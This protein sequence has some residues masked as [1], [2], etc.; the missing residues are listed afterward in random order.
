MTEHNL[1]RAA[2]AAY[3]TIILL[4]LTAEFLLRGQLIDGQDAA[5]TAAAISHHL[6]QFQLSIL[7]DAGMILADVALA[8]LLFALLRR[9]HAG[10]ALAAMVLRLMQAAVIAA[11]ALALIGVTQAVA[12]PGASE[13]VRQ[14]LALHAAGYDFGL[15]FFAGSTAITAWLLAQTSLVPRWLPP[16]LAGAAIVYLAGSATR[17]VAPE[18]NA[19]IQPAYLV[20]V[21]GET[22]LALS[23]LLRRGRGPQFA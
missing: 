16:L 12:L 5:L 2:G 9:V 13:L 22:A 17:F 10:L 11:S 6:M 14:L 23:L 4:G 18:L 8:M 15:I 3:V 20:P 21:I 7:A 1:S 19:L